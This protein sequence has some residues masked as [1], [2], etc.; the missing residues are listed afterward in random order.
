LILLKVRDAARFRVMERV[1]FQGRVSELDN[2]VIRVVTL[3][4]MYEIDS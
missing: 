1:R 4:D 3:A 2:K